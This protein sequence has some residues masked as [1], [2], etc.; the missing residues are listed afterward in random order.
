MRHDLIRK[1][2]NPK[3]KNRW[4]VYKKM[5]KTEI[6]IIICI[7]MTELCIKSNDFDLK[8]ITLF[9]MKMRRNAS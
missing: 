3:R 8:K 4:H 9:K 1:N 2:C 5:K 6:Y 7:H